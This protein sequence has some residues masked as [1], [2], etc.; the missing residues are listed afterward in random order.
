M[1]PAAWQ[2]T[3]KNQNIAELSG[4]YVMPKKAGSTTL[5]AICKDSNIG[6]VKRIFNIEV[7]P[8]S[9]KD[10]KVGLE[11]ETAAYDGKAHTPKVV[12]KDSKGSTLVENTDYTVEYS[13]NISVGSGRIVISGKGNYSGYKYIYFEITPCVQPLS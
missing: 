1:S 5:T 6:T 13:S 2:C 12:L 9:I 3:I 11:Y 4:E 8:C 10:M 7:L